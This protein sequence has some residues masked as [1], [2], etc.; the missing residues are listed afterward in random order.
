MP[1]FTGGQPRE[2]TLSLLFDATD[3]DSIDVV[4]VT[5]QLF[6]RWT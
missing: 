4:E 6:A 3:S 2:L 1:Q 5:T